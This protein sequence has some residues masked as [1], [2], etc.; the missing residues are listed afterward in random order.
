MAALPQR[1][2]RQRSGRYYFGWLAS[3]VSVRS[4]KTLC[5]CGLGGALLNICAA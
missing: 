3:A 1:S 4:L 5:T 2:S